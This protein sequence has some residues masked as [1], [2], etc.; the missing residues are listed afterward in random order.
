[1][2]KRCVA[3]LCIMLPL[4]LGS[5]VDPN[6]VDVYNAQIYQAATD[7]PVANLSGSCQY[8][9]NNYENVGL[10]I[11]GFLFNTGPTN[12]SGSVMINGTEYPCR[13][14]SLS[15]FQIQQVYNTSGFDR[16]VWITYHAAP[17]VVPQN[18]SVPE[19]AIIFAVFAVVLLIS[20]SVIGRGA[21]S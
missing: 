10:T 11:S 12:Y 13:L 5:W 19:F 6:V 14:N 15:E 7:Y 9:L 21:I 17:D 8:Y 18:Y 4:I 1:M 20:L 3:I 2:I 16:T